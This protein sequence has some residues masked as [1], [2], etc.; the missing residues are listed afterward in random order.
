M[1]GSLEQVSSPGL[2]G[3]RQPCPGKFWFL[4]LCLAGPQGRLPRQ[5]GVG[6]GLALVERARAAGMGNTSS[7]PQAYFGASP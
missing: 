6:I 5:T 1:L 2:F 7:G 3:S 4:F